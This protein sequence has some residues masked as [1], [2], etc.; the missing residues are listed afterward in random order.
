MKFI[1]TIALFFLFYAHTI[2]QDTTFVKVY[3]EDGVEITASRTTD[4]FKDG[5][6]ITGA[7][8]NE[9]LLINADSIANILW[10]KS[11]NAMNS[12]STFNDVLRTSDSSFL[13]TGQTYESGQGNKVL[14]LKF[15]QFGDTIWARSLRSSNNNS[16]YQLRSRA[17]E[18]IDSCYVITWANTALNELYIAKINLNGNL[19]W[20]RMINTLYLLPDAISTKDSSIYIGG[21]N[22]P[23]GGAILKMDLQGN[24]IWCKNYADKIIIDVV[25]TDSTLFFLY[26]Q[27]DLGVMKVDTTGNVAWAKKYPAGNGFGNNTTP[28]I[29]LLADN[30]LSIQTYST[31]WDDP[32]IKLDLNGDLIANTNDIM[33]ISD[34]A[35]HKYGG[36]FTIGTGPVFGI[37]S[38]L[39]SH[40]GV[41]KMDS[42]LTTSPCSMNFG[43]FTPTI[44]S[45][46][47]SAINYTIGS[48]VYF[49]SNTIGITDALLSDT[50]MCV[51]MF[52]G[53]NENNVADINVYPNVT[54]GMVHFEL[55]SYDNFSIEILSMDGKLV[56]ED[57]FKGSSFSVDLSALISGQYIYSITS[58]SQN[59]TGKIIKD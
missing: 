44:D 45:V 32:V 14:C 34:V 37:K 4:N 56:T 17:I 30:S 55:S 41:I 8:G 7:R 1:F 20:E 47:T 10:A 21:N 22:Y 29:T 54:K 38:F 26:G 46:S 53:L 23:D 49:V 25:E 5:F 48:S 18:T 6:I 35:P 33:F 9:A 50:N 16:M 24:V 43:P 13:V 39:N 15:D 19:V 58:D 36:L 3:Y 12:S 28:T 31:G 51:A 40:I 11:L 52:G 57:H 2:A 42:M 27:W 59:Y